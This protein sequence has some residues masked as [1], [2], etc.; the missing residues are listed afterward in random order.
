MYT[1]LIAVFL[2]NE[3][4]CWWVVRCWDRPKNVF[5]AKRER[6]WVRMGGGLGN[7]RVVWV[8]MGMKYIAW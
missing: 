2:S 6:R 4:E 1:G 8:N 3:R 7:W 5:G